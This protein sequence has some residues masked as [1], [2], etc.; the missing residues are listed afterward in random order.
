MELFTKL[1]YERGMLPDRYWYQLNGKSAQENYIEQRFGWR[2]DTEE[3]IIRSEI[4]VK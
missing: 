4:K 3:V 2:K 1:A